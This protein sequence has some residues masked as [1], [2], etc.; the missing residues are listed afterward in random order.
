M[1]LLKRN[2]LKEWGLTDEQIEKTMTEVSRGLSDYE[3]KSNVQALI[4]EEVAKAK[5]DAPQPVNVLESD[6]YKALLAKTQKL[7]AYQ[8]DD[9]SVVKSPYRD[10]VWEKLDHSE[11]HEDYKAQLDKLA[12]TMPDLFD[13]KSGEDQPQKTPQF[14]AST[15]G[16]LPSGKETPSFSD[17]WGY[18]PKK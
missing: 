5:A 14:G 12:E 1:A 10:I 9:F 6:E 8:T 11:K 2:T 16:T 3:L 7:E 13:I 15:Q 18:T 4:T 17:V